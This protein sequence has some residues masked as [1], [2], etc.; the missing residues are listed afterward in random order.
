MAGPGLF[1]ILHTNEAL[2]DLTRTVNEQ[3]ALQLALFRQNEAASTEHL[4]RIDNEIILF[5][6]RLWVRV[7][8][9][10]NI[11]A[12][13]VN[14]RFLP[15]E[16]DEY[17]ES[18][19][20]IDIDSLGTEE[21]E[22]SKCDICKENFGQP[23]GGCSLA[24]PL[25][26]P[27]APRSPPATLITITTTTS[28]SSSSSLTQHIVN[29]PEPESETGQPVEAVNPINAAEMKENEL[30]ENPV[31]LEC[32]HIFGEICLRRWIS[33]GNPPTCPTCRRVLNGSERGEG[34]AVRLEVHYQV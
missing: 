12:P 34:D 14:H 21:D 31:K 13:G 19:A 15:V 26:P 3:Y 8:F 32:G 9:T 30:P 22:D 18:L 33:D 6:Q 1:R 25:P 11:S 2:T 16:L 5:E 24:P 4:H 17:M 28:S 27:A 23:R 10:L 20:R 7:S 29:G